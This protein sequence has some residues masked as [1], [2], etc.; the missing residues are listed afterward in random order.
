M[1]EQTQ[2]SPDELPTW[3]ESLIVVGRM[4]SKAH[5]CS[6]SNS[7]KKIKDEEIF[8][9]DKQIN[10]QDCDDIVKELKNNQ[11]FLNRI[12]KIEIVDIT[13][14]REHGGFGYEISILKNE[15]ITAGKKYFN[16][17]ITRHFIHHRKHKDWA[18][19]K[20]TE[21]LIDNFMKK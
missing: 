10:E 15:S 14:K 13:C 2:W 19:K 4:I 12:H 7:V 21:D 9:N 3:N 16:V 20:L 6:L 5:G 17:K 11:E 1:K 8:F 18:I